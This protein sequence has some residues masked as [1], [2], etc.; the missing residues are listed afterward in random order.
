MRVESS[1]IV[2]VMVLS[3][4]CMDTSR[5]FVRMFVVGPYCNG[6]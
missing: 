2:E 5:A 1:F 6:R 3:S 4:L